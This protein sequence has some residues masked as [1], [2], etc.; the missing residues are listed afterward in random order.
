MILS[1]ICLFVYNRLEETIKTVDSLK[2]NKY[3]I[4]SIL[5]IFSDGPKSKDDQLKVNSV[6]KYIKSITGFKKILVIESVNNKGLANSIINGVQL[7]LNKF[8]TVIVL[9]DDLITSPIFLHYMNNALLKYKHIPSISTICGYSHNLSILN[10]YQKDVYFAVRPSSW[11]WATWNDRWSR[12]NWDDKFYW[13]FI[14]NPYYLFKL[15]KGGSDIIQMLLNQLNGKINSWAIK[16]TATQLINEN[17][18]VFPT[19]SLIKNN[20]INDNATNTKKSLRFEVDFESNENKKYFFP[21]QPLKDKIIHKQ[22]R[23]KYS[24]LARLRDKFIK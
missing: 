5:Y 14:Y 3:A 4:D 2:N 10:S 1:P 22:F 8:D 9:E 19:L 7:V 24:I 21:E 13:K 15:N 17:L 6:R 20:G 16:W 23:Q 12:V 11:G 18:S